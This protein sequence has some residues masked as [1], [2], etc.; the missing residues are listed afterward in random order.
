MPPVLDEVDLPEPEDEVPVVVVPKIPPTVNITTPITPPSVTD[1]DIQ[2]P[3]IPKPSFKPTLP[4]V[5]EEIDLPEEEEIAPPTII[6][7]IPKNP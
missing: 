6:P 4:P 5:L 3:E 7:A 1:P 2:E